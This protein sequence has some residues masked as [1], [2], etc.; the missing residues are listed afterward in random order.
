M[1][2]ARY[3]HVNVNTADL[4]PAEAFYGQGFGRRAAFRTA[5]TVDQ[6][7]AGFGLGGQSVRWNGVILSG[8]AREHGP[9]VDLLE[10]LEPATAGPARRTPS[11]LGH[12]CFQFTVPDLPAAAEAL[13]TV[14][15]TCRPGARREGPVPPAPLIVALDPDGTR[16]ELVDGPDVAMV[17]V[18]VNCSDLDRS[19]AFY[20]ALGMTVGEE[21]RVEITVDGGTGPS[22]GGTLRARSVGADRPGVFAIELAEW[23]EPAPTGSAPATGNHVG[24]YRIALMVDD[25]DAAYEQVLAAVG[26]RRLPSTSTSARTVPSSGRS[27]SPIPTGRSSSS[28]AD[29][30]AES[31]PAERPAL[32]EW[33]MRPGD[34][35]PGARR[36]A[37]VGQK[38]N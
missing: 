16:V 12:A 11:E 6:D 9:M 2:G 23:E 36:P 28:S 25:V 24:I 30:P 3:Y 22:G 21:R 26:R 8:T 1:L 4:A 17:G 34:G 18:R 27:S 32:S 7:G 20:A 38:N 33:P 19:A 5:P 14:G 37:P 13:T 15:G 29:G 35:K 31:G 10:W